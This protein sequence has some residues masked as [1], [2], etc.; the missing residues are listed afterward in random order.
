MASL[1]GTCKLN[2]INPQAYLEHAL[3]KILGGHMKKDIQE[4]M[5]W[6]FKRY[7]SLHS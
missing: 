4:L 5:P 2:C 1:T 7:G 6:N 3:G